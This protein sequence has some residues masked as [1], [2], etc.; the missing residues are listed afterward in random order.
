METTT[1]SQDINRSSR[2][3][4]PAI[5]TFFNR[6]WWWTTLLVLA[7]IG[8]LVRLGL[9]Q[10]DRLEQRRTENTQIVQQLG[11]PPIDLANE[12]LPADLTALKHRQAQVTG[13]YDLSHQIAL[14]HQN[15]MNTP[16]FHLVTPLLIEGTS[17]AVLVDRGWLPAAQLDT[18]NW[19]QYKAEGPVVITGYIQLSQTVENSNSSDEPVDQLQ[20][21]WY[22]VDVDA[23]EAQLPYELLPVYLQ[24]I[25]ADEG[26]ERL[27]YRTALDADLS[28]GNHL[29]YAIQ[30]FIF[31]TIL[32]FG[33]VYFVGK[34]SD[35]AAVD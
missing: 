8:L 3:Q 27:P 2:F 33:Y 29:S 17:Q 24:Q 26:S 31:A 21:E 28:E 1:H 20:R 7:G 32:A 10:L 9:W 11:L 34:R 12:P 25:P 14:V 19:T 6:Q 5:T 4:L 23:I 18:E 13:E 22:R 35:E 16:G 30:W 15:W